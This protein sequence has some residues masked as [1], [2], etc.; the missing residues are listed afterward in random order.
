[1]NTNIKEFIAGFF[2]PYFP[3]TINF[4]VSNILSWDLRIINTLIF[5]GL[6]EILLLFIGSLYEIFDVSYYI[7][8]MSPAPL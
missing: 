2:R 1:M 6:L 3:E 8:V 5:S 4:L 7:L